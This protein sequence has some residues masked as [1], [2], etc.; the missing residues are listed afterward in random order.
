MAEFVWAFVAFAIAM[1][2]ACGWLVLRNLRK[3]GNLTHDTDTFL[4]NP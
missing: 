3:N 2:F 1:A 4:S